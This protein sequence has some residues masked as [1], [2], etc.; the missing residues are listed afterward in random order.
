[1]TP[2]GLRLVFVRFVDD[3]NDDGRANADDVP[4]LWS[5]LVDESLFDGAAAQVATPLTAGDAGEIFVAVAGNWLA[6]TTQAG[7]DLEIYALPLSGV[8]ATTATADAVLAAARAEE[9]TGLRRLALRHLIATDPTAAAPAH[10]ELARDLAD[11]GRLTD[12]I[13]ELELTIASSTGEEERQLAALETRR[14]RLLA[15]LGGNWQTTQPQQLRAVDEAGREIARLRLTTPSPASYRRESLLGELSLAR[16]Q[17]SDAARRFEHLGRDSSA[18]PEDAARALDHLAV[19][20]ARLGDLAAVAR[21]STE[22][23][24]RLAAERALARRNAIRWVQAVRDAKATAPL[25]A[26]DALASETRVLPRVAARALSALAEEQTAQGFYAQAETTRWRIAT[27]YAGERQIVAETLLALGAGAE[28]SGDSATAL[29][30]YERL[31]AD[32]ADDPEL[33]ARGRQGVTRIALRKAREEEERGE[34]EQARASYQ[35]LLRADAEQVVAHRRFIALSARLGKLVAVVEDYR[36]AAS[37]KPRDKV[38]RYAYGYA[39]TFV[40]PLPRATSEHEITAALVLDPRMAVAHLTLGWLREQREREDPAHGWLEAAQD[41]YETA[42]D[43][44]DTDADAELYAATLLNRGN[45]LAALGKTDAAFD[46]FRQRI[47]SPAPF[48]DPMTELLFYESFARVAL[49]EQALDVALDMAT[50]EHQLADKLPGKPRLAVAASLRAALFLLAEQPARAA[51]WYARAADIY[52]AAG[53]ESRLVPMLRGVALSQQATGNDE[54]ALAAWRRVFAVL[55]RGEGPEPTVS[56][57]LANEDPANPDNVTRAI[58]GFSSTQEEEIARAQATRLLLRR[59]DLA[60]ARTYD[61][62]RLALLF[63]EA[64]DARLGPRIAVELLHGLHESAL[65][66]ARAGDVA[67]VRRRW[68]Q[69]IALAHARRWWPALATCLESLLQARVRLKDDEALSTPVWLAATSALEAT[70]KSQPDL[71]R[72]V[73]GL[74]ALAHLSMAVREVPVG[75][76][77]RR[78][79]WLENRLRAL[80]GAVSEA[81][82]ARDYAH[83]ALRPELAAPF[84]GDRT[85]PAARAD[86]WRASFG[87]ALVARDRGDEGAYERALAQATTAFEQAPTAARAPELDAFVALAARQLMA[88]GDAE[89]AWRLLERHRLLDL[90]PDEARVRGSSI[91]AAWQALQPSRAAPA[92]FFAEAAKGPML[93]RAV[94]AAPI[95]AVE[96]RSRLAPQTGLLQLFRPAGDSS[97]GFVCTQDGLR[98]VLSEGSGTESVALLVAEAHEQGVRRLYV[99]LGETWADTPASWSLGGAPLGTQ[100]VVNEVLSATYFAA[101]LQARSLSRGGLLI[102]GGDR[103]VPEALAIPRRLATPTSFRRALGDQALIYLRLPLRVEASP[104]ERAGR[105]QIVMRGGGA[106]SGVALDLDWLAHEDLRAALLLVE[107]PVAPSRGRRALLQAALL[108][109][110]PTVLFDVAGEGAPPLLTRVSRELDHESLDAILTA[111]RA[112]GIVTQATVGG[113]G[114]FDF[115]AR[116][117]VAVEAYRRLATEAIAAFKTAQGAPSP[118]TWRVA[119]RRFRQ[120]LDAM[121]FLTEPASVALLTRSDDAVTRSLPVSLPKREGAIRSI[122]AQTHLALGEIEDAAALQEELVADYRRQGNAAGV[123]K[124]TAELGKT[125]AHG[126]EHARAADALERCTRLAAELR[127]AETEADCQSRLGTERRAL[128]ELPAAVRAYQKAILAYATKGSRNEIYPR[129]YLG[130]LYESGLNNFDKA[131]EQF[132]AAQAVASRL[133]LH[134]IEAELLLDAARIYRQVASYDDAVE[135][136]ERAARLAEEQAPTVRGQASL[137]LAKIEW[138]RGNYRRARAHETTALMLARTRADVFLEIQ[139]LSL[140]GLIA[141]NQGDFVAAERSIEAA[142]SLA[143][144]SGRRSEEAA[145]LNNLGF[146]RRESGKLV[147]AALD[148]RSALVIDESLGSDEGRAYDLRNLAIA[149]ARQGD[150]SQALAHLEQALVLSRKTSSRYN[151][152]QSLLARAQIFESLADA[153]ATED[154]QASLALSRSLQVPE[155]EWSALYGLA[156]VSEGAGNRGAARRLAGEALVVAEQLG[157]SRDSEEAEHTRR[158]LYADAVRLALAEDD[159]RTA[160]TLAERAR[161][162]RLLDVL[163]SGSVSLPSLEAGELLEQEARTR[164]ALA[165]VRRQEANDTAARSIAASQHD[166][167]LSALV[168]RYPRLARV[169]TVGAPALAELQEVLPSETVVLS[170]YIARDTLFLFA[171][172]SSSQTAVVVPVTRTQ[173]RTHVRD[174][175]EGITALGAVDDT[176]TELSQLL[177]APVAEVL[178]G[179]EHVVIVADGALQQVPFAALSL[180]GAALLEHFSLSYAPTLGLLFDL[181]SARRATR[182]RSFASFAASADL[183]YARLEAL[184]VGGSAARLGAQASETALRSVSADAVD[185]ATHAELDADDPLGSALVLAATSADDG[186]LETREIFGLH[187]PPAL[188]ALSACQTAGQ[189]LA[190]E[191]WVSL[192]SAYLTAGTRTVVASRQRVADLATGVTM[193]RFF[194][195]LATDSPANALRR[196]MLET[197]SRFAHPAHWAGLALIGDFR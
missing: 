25:V 52:Q 127:D 90:Q 23:Q 30:A 54:L 53:D 171:T 100:F 193:K 69:A 43:L 34:P 110:I 125:L 109:G 140:E 13:A 41:S 102:F 112:D 151:E 3:A 187:A 27:D 145:Q 64:D 47:V 105:T 138:Y 46:A 149:L 104:L 148:F 124:T 49:R 126:D 57:W 101:T 42:R 40:R 113:D 12:A 88:A 159:T 36:Q 183:P 17:T 76:T 44:L 194:R 190:T 142:L 16:G 59:G 20:Y 107:A 82:L 172:G 146:V 99:D 195:R 115:A 188:V 185:V 103:V 24:Q 96:L 128:F 84:A 192:A 168:Q 61:A 177:I 147:A 134:D 66:A 26:L 5:V 186:R 55:K 39:L 165:R 175:V 15:V 158:D 93:L 161:S 136:A 169:F 31:L 72:Q 56:P 106:D 10:Y 67:H 77:T 131:L 137:E 120:L 157:R 74:L 19:I 116:V 135:Y 8:I 184:A 18:P 58:Y 123:L 51:D 180:D 160:F 144:R 179:A 75:D 85:L 117:T 197:R 86:G 114:G 89:H 62:R 79:R 167:A 7:Q 121:V 32:F 129:R 48:G 176:L 35:R 63:E 71:S 4:S 94:V 166:Q 37:K 80:D 21:V 95:T 162:R 119:Q 196:A 14:L 170:Y 182:P 6:Y 87:N 133:A 9:R 173:L 73:A 111:A 11:R 141:V 38:L 1:M 152:L 122:L 97:F 154:Y 92:Q 81:A 68:E 78:G 155:V 91:G 118:L 163:G 139:S 22:L 28:R 178:R 65:L 189:P 130:F 191:A 164:E 174:L 2:Q 50:Q 60:T 45:V 132:Q 153:R 33:R 156:R 83:L 150:A 98:G 143:R 108:A 70:S 29:D 181:L